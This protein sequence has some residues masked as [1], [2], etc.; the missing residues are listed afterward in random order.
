MMILCTKSGIKMST[1][2]IQSEIPVV[3]AWQY[4]CKYIQ[5][6][7]NPCITQKGHLID[8]SWLRSI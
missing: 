1:N 2:C 6:C 7:E 8:I 5:A 3:K 4:P